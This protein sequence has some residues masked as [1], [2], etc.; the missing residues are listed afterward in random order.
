MRQNFADRMTGYVGLLLI[1]AL[2]KGTEIVKR[3]PRTRSDDTGQ[4]IQA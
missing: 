2:S 4:P 3:R 1:G